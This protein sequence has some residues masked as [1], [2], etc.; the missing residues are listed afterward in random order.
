[1]R[2]ISLAQIKRPVSSSLE[3]EDMQNLM[4]W[5]ILRMGLLI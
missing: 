2:G 3:S 1:M 5:E 4:I